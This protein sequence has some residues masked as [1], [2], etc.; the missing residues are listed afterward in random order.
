MNASTSSEVPALGCSGYPIL[1]LSLLRYSMLSMLVVTAIT[2]SLENPQI[3]LIGLK[4]K[5]VL[6]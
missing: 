4:N 6:L 3:P 1:P 2:V 5:L